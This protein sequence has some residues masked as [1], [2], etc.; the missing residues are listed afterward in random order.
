MIIPPR[1]LR[2]WQRL[3]VTQKIALSFALL[4]GLVI[5]EGFVGLLVLGDVRR[6]EEVIRSSAE[7]RQRVFEMDGQL[8]K[9]R[10]LHRDFFLQ[11]PHI[12]YSAA[13]S[14]YFKPATEIIARVAASSEDLKRLIESVPVSESLRSRERDLNLYLSSARRFS[15]TFGELVGLVTQL[16][17]PDTGLEHE[18]AQQEAILQRAAAGNAA[19]LLP[20]REM[21]AS[22]RDYMLTR[23]RPSMQ[24]AMNACAALHQALV[25]QGAASRPDWPAVNAALARYIE[26]ARRIPDIDV[27]IHSKM[28]DFA[29]QAKAVDP[30]SDELKTL[31]SAEVERAR[32]RIEKASGLSTLIIVLAAFSGLCLV[33][34]VAAIVHKS[35][36]SKLVALTRSAEQLRSGNLE[37]R[38]DPGAEDEIGV[39]AAS[40]NDM[41][42]RMR[43]LVGNLEQAVAQRTS[44]L[45]E[46]RDRLQALV[47]ELDEKNQTL[48]V[49]SVTD[50]LTGL[51]NRRKLESVLQSELQRA[52]R[53][54][55][56]FSII[57]LDV[58]RFKAINDTFG[59]STGDSVL[60]GLADLL[61]TNA[62]DTD[63]VGRWGGEEFL[64]ICPETGPHLV[65]TLAERYRQAL[66]M[67]DFV[68][69]GHITASFGAT[70]S[71]EGDSVEKLMERADQALY[72]AKD[73]GRNR[74][75]L[76][77]PEPADPA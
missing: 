6:T 56:H 68:L 76:D 37:V 30:I 44:E 52:R 40:F 1:L 55:K 67:Q 35:I 61:R 75:E 48:K 60:A 70:A 71:Q 69:A 17:A 34:L 2:A 19:T 36:T 11:Y 57:L 66:E 47:R 14:L 12:G 46:A 13:Q 27:Q 51:A 42:G 8:E 5:V 3:G 10:R 38:V 62:R 74:V 63:L 25:F 29:L 33:L 54:G 4:F 20:L 72:R 73:A 50:R 64:I 7:I 77:M 24:S 9:A 59:H 26:A 16:A 28:N 22:Q 21:Q 31:A 53:Y 39:L 32:A 18:L 15:D 45:T 65:A 41:S 23:Q 43:E 49:L 58:D